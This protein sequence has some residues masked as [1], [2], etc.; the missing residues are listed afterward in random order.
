MATVAQIEANRQNAQKSTGPRT[1][2]GKIAAS[3]NALTHGFTAAKFAV[4]PSE[5]PGAYEA[6]RQAWRSRCGDDPFQIALADRGCFAA[7]QLRRLER[8]ADA[9]IATQV[10]SAAD[11]FDIDQAR[12]AHDLGARLFVEG[13]ATDDPTAI[14]AELEY[15]AAGVD[16]MI[17]RWNELAAQLELQKTW[18]LESRVHA[19]QLMGKRPEHLLQDMEMLGLMCACAATQ[20]ERAT[21]LDPSYQNKIAQGPRSM[22]FYRMFLV[23]ESNFKTP[24]AGLAALNDLVQ[25]QLDHLYAL[26][27]DGLDAR[28]AADRADA[29]LRALFESNPEAEKM[30]RYEVHLERTLRNCIS[31]ILKLSREAQQSPA[32]PSSAPTPAPVA[33]PVPNETPEWS[34]GPGRPL[35]NEANPRP[36]SD[37]F[38]PSQ[39]TAMVVNAARP[40]PA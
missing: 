19:V 36:A 3:A 6:E 40:G 32:P 33:G 1:D 16:W 18:K 23:A 21:L 27:N 11:R 8:A 15:F 14:V 35:R 28:A 31:G 22:H 10:R 13:I 24:E 29:P 30:R 37:Q 17:A 20:P 9:C 26:K 34:P 2:E 7:R 39:Q 4:L 5:D 25:A 12:M 38:H